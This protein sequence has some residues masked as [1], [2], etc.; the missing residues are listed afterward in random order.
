MDFQV[1][2]RLVVE[3]NRDAALWTRL[4]VGKEMGK[5]RAGCSAPL[6]AWQPRGGETRGSI[7]NGHLWAAD[8]C[9]E[10][11]RKQRA[12]KARPCLMNTPGG[13]QK[14]LR[15]GSLT[16]HHTVCKC[17]W[18]CWSSGVTCSTVTNRRASQSWEVCACL[19]LQ[20]LCA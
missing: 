14:R 20:D 17:S 4:P 7:G 15:M 18:G 13:R 1:F 19:Q 3:C 9:Q 8:E 2:A 16:S 10:V 6:R 12:R 5:S 11:G